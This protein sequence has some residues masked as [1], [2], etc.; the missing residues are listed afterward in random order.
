MTSP[1][2]R[3][4][5]V[6]ASTKQFE[7]Y[8]TF[9]LRPFSNFGFLKRLPP[10]RMWGPY[11]ELT[12]N[13]WREFLQIFREHHIVPLVAITA[14]WVDEQ[15]R[16]IPF[17]E[18]FPDE[19]AVLKQAANRGEIQIANH[20]LTHCVVGKHLPRPFSSN[21]VFHREFLPTLEQKVHTQHIQDSQ[22][23]LETYFGRTIDTLV[24][25]GNLWSI[26]TY[27]ALEGTNLKKIFCARPMADAQVQ[28]QGVEYLDDNHGVVRFHD[29]ELRLYG[30]PWL[31]ET[32]AKHQSRP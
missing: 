28:M 6:G 26:K 24:P 2:F 8:G 22:R 14:C 16:L 15:A 12:G 23:I 19:A 27:R 17:P 1:L 10:F 32:I 11:E 9:R 4:D 30:T 31:E 20:G 3:I 18:K 25:P 7:Q 29:R 5:D 21:R 13:E